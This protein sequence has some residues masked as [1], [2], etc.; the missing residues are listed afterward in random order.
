LELAIPDYGSIE[1]AAPDVDTLLELL[2]GEHRDG[3]LYRGQTEAYPHPLFPSA[4]R[5]Y[6][7]THATYTRRSDEFSSAL[8]NVGNDFVGLVPI[9]FFQESPSLFYPEGAEVSLPELELL[10]QLSNDQYLARTLGE[11][12]AAFEMMLTPLQAEV[13]RHRF[14]WWKE[15]IDHDHRTQIRD[16]IFMRP[17]GYL[18]GQALAQQYGFSSEMLD[19]TTD[20]DVAAFFATHRSQAFTEARHDGVGVIY[21]F[22]V[23]R[24]E[25]P[26]D[27]GAYDFYSC[28]PVLLLEELIAPF[29]TDEECDRETIEQFLVESFERFQKWRRWDAFRIS[30]EALSRTRIARQGAAFLVPDAIYVESGK[31][32]RTHRLLMAI[33]DCATRTGCEAFYFRH[34]EAKR[35]PDLSREFLWPNET[36]V[37]FEMIG[38][39]L[40]ANVRLDTG[41][42]LPSRIDLLD[43]GYRF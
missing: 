10:T 26:L 40:L 19:L 8:R 25:S 30:R 4:Y 23:E 28:P 5:R 14:P 27:L 24:R 37:L 31:R 39:A 2:R 21:R 3:F 43:P 20:I 36:D 33:E 18:L 41:Q 1:E 6:R 17:F 35:S 12:P 32:P 29:V 42:I 38:N 34:T 16:M 22:P 13:F 7:R 9:N 11:G 15:V